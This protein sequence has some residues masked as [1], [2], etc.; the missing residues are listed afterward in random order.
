MPIHRPAPAFAEQNVS[1]EMLETGIKVMDLLC[2]IVRG[3]KVGIPGGAGVGKTVIQKELIRNITQEHGGVAVFAGVGE[4]TREG[5]IS[6][7][8]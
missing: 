2:P 5:T 1:T 7:W 8:R 6:G 4:R 3:G